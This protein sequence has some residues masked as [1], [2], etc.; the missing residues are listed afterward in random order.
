MFKTS[1]SNPFENLRGKK[2]RKRET[3]GTKRNLII[4]MDKGGWLIEK[5]PTSVV[6]NL[7]KVRIREL[8]SSVLARIKEE[9]GS[10]EE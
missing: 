5:R 9:G 7:K 1:F 10:K 2:R 3:R 8:L 4:L 6:R